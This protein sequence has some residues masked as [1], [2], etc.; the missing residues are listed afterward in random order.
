M[1]F[2]A[3]IKDKTLTKTEKIIAD[4]LLDNLNAIGFSSVKEVSIACGVS[5][6]SI[7]RFLRELGYDGYTDFKKELNEKLLEQY[8]A[9][10]SP[11]Q[12]FNQSKANIRPNSVVNDV[13]CNSMKNLAEA[14]NNIDEKLLEKI[15]DCLIA[16]RKK[17]I[18]AFRGTSCCADYFYRKAIYFLPGLVLCNKAESK[19]ME[20]LIDIG[21]QDCLLLFS[22]PRYSEIVYTI[23]ELAKKRGAKI[24]IFTDR[25]TSP[26]AS[27]ADYLVTVNVTGFSY[28]NSYVVPLCCAEALA[29]IISKKLES[30]ADTEER[31]RLLE[32]Y[33]Y[34]AKLY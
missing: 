20:Q 29:V 17:Y 10:L 22:F 7:I 14:L 6:T 21:P 16:S 33:I 11:M 1:D 34:K 32:D 2:T 5:D 4:Y 27:F 13:F 12:K 8:N 31:L 19:A 30:N 23:L 18:A 26:L 28:T 9:S 25:V 15:A 3:R 24:I